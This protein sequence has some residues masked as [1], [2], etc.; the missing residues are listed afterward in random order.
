MLKP[1]SRL[2]MRQ[3][4]EF[5][6]PLML[7][8]TY[9]VGINGNDSSPTP[10]NPA[11][12]YLTVQ[13]A[14]GAAHPGD[15][16][17]VS[18]GVY[19]EGPI[20][21]PRS[22]TAQSPIAIEAASGA[23]VS[24]K[25]SQVVTGWVSV[26]N[27]V[28]KKTGWSTNSQQLFNDGQPL[29]QVASTLNELPPVGSGLGDVTAGRFYYSS[30][31]QTL[32][33]KLPDGSD[34]NGHAME[35]SVRNSVLNGNSMSYITLRGLSFMHSNGSSAGGDG[36]SGVVWAD[37][38]CSNWNI[39]NCTFSYGDFA[40]LMLGGRNHVVRNSSF[41]NNGD[42]G[43]GLSGS[44]AAHGYNPYYG[45]PLQNILLENLTV[46]GNNYRHFDFYWHAGGMKIIPSCRGVTVRGCTVSNNWGPGI[47]FDTVWGGNV[48]ENNLVTNN[49]DAGIFY[50]ISEPDTGDTYG[51]Q[52]R[53]N[54][55]AGNSQGIYVSAS[56]GAIVENNT[57]YRNDWD[58]VVHGMPRDG[59]NH[60]MQL[61]N[62]VVRNNIICGLNV[63]AIIYTGAGSS[64]NS[65]DGNFYATSPGDS[66][67]V[68][69]SATTVPGYNVTQ[70]SLA[71][72]NS[73]TGF[74]QHGMTGD[75]LWV[76][77]SR[78][79]FHLQAGSPAAGKGWTGQDIQ[80]PTAGVRQT[81]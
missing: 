54:R 47:W 59:W 40:G 19:R 55:V 31:A 18:G 48:I 45:A 21:L 76:N 9:Y 53:N 4:M 38:S 51:A 39:E 12:P 13:K 58:I 33:C 23:T 22:G 2:K 24:I 63:D 57:C 15:A 60:P 1:I 25:G 26:G 34:P 3:L 67:G 46:T 65:I 49:E 11:T 30:S 29:Q 7:L 62:N 74:E 66:N 6:E 35:A 28:W 32:Y 80:A 71:T 8:S 78:Y 69:F 73:Q 20:I 56:A 14:I 52:I 75:P 72:I 27:G 68:T 61:K 36:W 70:T 77:A 79:D 81:K 5:L 41:V 44:D 42:E 50:E 10:T 43:I 37:N 16:I 17:V 64:N